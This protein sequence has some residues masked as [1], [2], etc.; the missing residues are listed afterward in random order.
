MACGVCRVRWLWRVVFVACVCVEYVLRML[1]ACTW[2]GCVCV[3]GLRVCACVRV[4]CV[5][6]TQ[7]TYKPPTATQHT[8][9]ARTLCTYSTAPIVRTAHTKDAPH[10][11]AHTHVQARIHTCT[12]KPANTHTPH[13]PNTA[14]STHTAKT[15]TRTVPTANTGR[16]NTAHT[17]NIHLQVSPHTQHEHHTNTN[18]STD[19]DIPSTKTHTSTSHR[20]TPPHTHHTQHTRRVLTPGT[21]RCDF[22]PLKMFLPLHGVGGSDPLQQSSKTICSFVS[23]GPFEILWSPKAWREIHG[24]VGFGL[25]RHSRGMCTTCLRINMPIRSLAARF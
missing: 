23:V 3:C 8:H 22:L 24:R 17:A 6:G 16:P 12:H 7:Y 1:C 18:T 11:Q 20:H 19:T 15:H 13:P 2:M 21:P 25:S 9:A 10:R 14:R 4:V 5:L